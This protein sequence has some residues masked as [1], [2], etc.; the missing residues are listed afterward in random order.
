VLFD[1]D[2]TLLDAYRSH[3]RVYTHVFRALGHELDEAAYIRA[4]SPNW[5][6][7][8]ERLGVPKERWPEADRLW[9]HYY[10]QE[11]PQSQVGA[12][13][14]LTAIQA[15]GRVLGLVTAG[16]RSRVERDLWR[17]GWHERFQVV[18]CGG[19]VPERKPHPAPLER[20]LHLAGMSPEVALYVGDTPEDVAMGKAAGVFTAAILG[21]FSGP[22]LFEVST[23]DV[24]L[25]SLAD[26]VAILVG[27]A[28]LGSQCS[29]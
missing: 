10:A 12:D 15:S 24:R 26:L 14:V 19:D 21:G 6:Q 4:Y 13:D 23:P 11:E 18:V 27:H 7:L 2:G 22:D 1:L 9:L 5:Y 28:S 25:N 3:Y 20:A 16:D 8:Y 29:S 17:M